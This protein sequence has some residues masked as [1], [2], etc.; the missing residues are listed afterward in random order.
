MSTTTA[1]LEKEKV[2]NRIN[3]KL[4]S[5]ARA[6]VDRLADQT[7]STITELVRL[8]LSLLRIAIEEIR[9]GNKLII[10]TADGQ[11]LRELVIPGL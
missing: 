5:A 11:P 3:L 8:S 1:I 4:S 2:S 7:H 10:T 9:K 6:D